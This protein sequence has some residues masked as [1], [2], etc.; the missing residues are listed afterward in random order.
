[1]TTLR[2]RAPH[3]EV[4]L[5]PTPVQGEG[6]AQRIANAIRTASARAECDVLLVC[7]G[8]GSIEDL[9]SFNEE[10]VARA[11]VEASMP[12]ISGVGHETDFT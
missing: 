3:V 12:V 9:W 2:R 4:I 8:G 7:R 1:L 11:I 5:Y 10:V 6:S